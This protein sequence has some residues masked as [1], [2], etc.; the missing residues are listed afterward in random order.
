M[1]RGKR[2]KPHSSPFSLR[3]E[4]LNNSLSSC[5]HTPRA[6]RRLH[7]VFEKATE[8]QA[9]GGRDLDMVPNQKRRKEET[10]RTEQDRRRNREERCQRQWICRVVSYSQG[11]HAAA[12]Q[13]GACTGDRESGL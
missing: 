5:G 4:R 10:R 11:V 13:S 8:L 6:E 2:L 1:R 9:M 12:G 3:S 7:E